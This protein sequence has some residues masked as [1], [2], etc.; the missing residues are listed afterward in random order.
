ML[1]IGPEN[2][3]IYI[4]SKFRT[5]PLAGTASGMASDS[6]RGSGA[7]YYLTFDINTFV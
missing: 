4:L 6:V 7:I 5:R 1:F 2:R 3:I